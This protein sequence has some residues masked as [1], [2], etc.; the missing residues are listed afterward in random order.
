MKGNNDLELVEQK[1]FEESYTELIKIIHRFTE[2]P[3]V[4][5]VFQ[6]AKDE[7]RKK[8]NRENKRKNLTP[9]FGPSDQSRIEELNQEIKS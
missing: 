6:K 9:V 3:S 2:A 1:A 4:A 7:L 5:D 8:Q